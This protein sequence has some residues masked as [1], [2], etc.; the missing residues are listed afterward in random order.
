MSAVTPRG[1]V[2]AELLTV[3]MQFAT[4]FEA[5]CVVT[6]LPDKDG[7]FLAFDSDGVECS[8][9]VNMVERIER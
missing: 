3:G 7:D 9:H 5:G 1:M 2:A 4:P 8:F 6:T